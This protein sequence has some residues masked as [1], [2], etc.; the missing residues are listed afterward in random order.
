MAF[1]DEITTSRLRIIPLALEHF[2][3][4][5]GDPAAMEAALGLNRSGMALGEHER[6][7]MLW[8]YGMA[9]SHPEEHLWFTNW[10]IVL[11]AGNVSIGSACFKGGPGEKGEVEI[12]YG[13]NT[14][15]RNQGYM[16]EAAEALSW[17]AMK[18][19]G[20]SAVIAE[21][22]KDNPASQQV[23]LKTRMEKF[24]ETSSTI[25]WRFTSSP[26][27]GSS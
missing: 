23:C 2:A 25:L 21:T 14:A 16:T 24:G 11:A 4:L 18:Q 5:L 13:I 6:E 1:P 7:A 10:Q 8:L 9:Q 3:L 26:R 27:H 15:Y 19:P 20:V 12:G 22:D 17:W